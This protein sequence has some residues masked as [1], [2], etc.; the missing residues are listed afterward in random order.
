M[1][2]YEKFMKKR[3]FIFRLLHFLLPS[4]IQT[5]INYFVM[6]TIRTLN[7]Q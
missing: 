4:T 3:I 5:T 6:S 1:K 2:T 7:Q